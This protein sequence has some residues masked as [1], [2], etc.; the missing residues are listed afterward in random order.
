[1]ATS[2]GHNIK[3][4]V[5]GTDRLPSIWSANHGFYGAPNPL[6]LWRNLG[7]AAAPSLQT[8]AIS[9]DFNTTALSSI[10]SQENPLSDCSFSAD[11]S[12]AVTSLPGG[13]AHDLW[14]AGNFGCRLMQPMADSD[15]SVEA[16]FDSLLTAQFQMQGILF[17]Q[18]ASNYLRFES[19]YDGA[20]VH[21]FEASF[22]QDIPTVGIDL[23]IGNAGNSIWLRVTR[24][25]GIWSL[26]WSTDGLNFIKA[27]TFSYPLAARR[28]GVYGGNN[29]FSV[30]SGVTARGDYFHVSVP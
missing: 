3:A 11:G 26:N 2:G 24:Q 5:V 25:G 8:R 20:S 30:S 7:V 6:E 4:G 16:K 27:I 13:Q 29:G 18:D 1:L 22:I 28:V 17:Q 10:W 23:P 19:Y 12:D 15:I 9:D 21:I 14:S